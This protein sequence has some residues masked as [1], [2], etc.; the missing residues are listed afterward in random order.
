MD[1]LSLRAQL[2]ISAPWLA[3]NTQWG[4]LLPIVL[5]AQIAAL[6]PA[7]K[8]LVL[9]GVMDAGALVALVVT[10][11]AGALSDRARGGRRPFVLYGALANAL[12]LVLLGA[13]G[14]HAP[15]AAFVGAVLALQLATNVWGGPYAATIPDRI[16]PADRAVASGW[17]M[18]MTVLGTV[19][20]AVVSGTLVQRGQF[21]AAYAFIA[22]V[23]VACVLVSFAPAPGTL[24]AAPRPA[25]V[26]AAPF[27]PPLRENRAFYLVLITRA[28]ITMGIYS[29]YGFFLYFLADVVRVAQPAT[30]GSLLLGIA[31]LA[32]VPAALAAGRAS[33]RF[34]VLRIVVVSS[35]TMALF[36]AAFIAV[37]YAPSWPATIV[38]AIAYGAANCA[39]QAVDWALAIEVLPDTG[40]A[41][42]DMGIWHVSFVLPQAI[43]P[44]VTGLAIALAKPVSLQLGY[45][46]AFSLA[47]LWFAIGTL[48]VTRLGP[49]RDR[50]ARVKV[51]A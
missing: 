31:A 7:N 41:G 20:G 42:K 4:A 5:P 14:G 49:L 22:L 37:V 29:V 23:L 17:M 35:A 8:E 40:Q 45:A 11:L 16:P 30:S 9:G 34:G 12:V 51:P 24:S 25:P 39:Y 15:L 32:G 48:A 26:T 18:V 13:L 28:F 3:Y 19:A 50:A 38:L 33:R 21:F 1:R 10:P 36:A 46:V 43:A 44:G 27:F 47:A 2:T 6:A